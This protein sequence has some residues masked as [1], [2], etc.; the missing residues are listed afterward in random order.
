MLKSLT[1]SRNKK[2]GIGHPYLTP[3]VAKKN[4]DR[5]P[6]VKIVKDVEAKQRIIQSTPN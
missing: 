6:F 2:G 5:E 4:F 3:L 1:T